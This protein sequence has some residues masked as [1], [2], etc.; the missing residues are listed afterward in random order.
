M[1]TDDF[2]MLRWGMLVYDAL[3]AWCRE[4]HGDTAASPPVQPRV[5]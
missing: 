3:Y 1:F 5:A 4:S 2:A